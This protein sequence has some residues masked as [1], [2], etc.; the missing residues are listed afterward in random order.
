MARSPSS[1]SRRAPRKRRKSSSSRSSGSLWPWAGALIVVAGAIAVYDSRD[2]WQASWPRIAALVQPKSGGAGK[3]ADG[4]TASKSSPARTVPPAAV[5]ST[6]KPKPAPGRTTAALIPPAPVGKTLPQALPQQR[7]SEA[8]MEGRGFAGTFY[9]CGTSGLDNCVASGDTFWHHKT[10][11]VLADAVAPQTERAKCQA[12]RDKGFAAKVRLKELLNAGAFD[13]VA[14]GMP[15]A[16][17]GSEYKVVLRNGRS[18][19]AVLLNDGLAQP[20][21]GERKGWCP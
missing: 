20:R 16:A 17:S 12:E 18:L 11:I 19:G 6:A 1:S 3:G 15:V 7:P 2:Q 4:G 8:G 13:L 21:A 10:K 9:Y 14:P 5:G